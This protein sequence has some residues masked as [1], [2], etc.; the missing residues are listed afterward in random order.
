[1]NDPR[2]PIG[3]FHWSGSL[4][5]DERRG[6]IHAIADTP[7]KLRVAVDGLTDRQLDTPYREGGW[8]VRQIVHHLPDSHL[9]AYCRMRLALTEN[10]PLIKPYDEAAWAELFDARTTTIEPSLILLESL[11]ARWTMLLGSLT[12]L[13]FARTFRHPEYTEPRS[14]NWLVAL[15]AWHGPHHI[16]HITTL[17]E[18][19]GW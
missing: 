16:A 9:N 6:K 5:D 3:N 10:E 8:T 7:K 12:E 1:M 14:L 13:D 15:Y 19:M 18:K 11:H 2:F 17:R 4:T